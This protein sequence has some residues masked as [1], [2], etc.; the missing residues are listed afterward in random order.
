MKLKMLLVL[1]GNTDIRFVNGLCERFDVTILGPKSNLQV[2]GGLLDRIKERGLKVDVI[3]IE[4]GR[5]KYQVAAFFQLL[6]V[7]SLFDFIFSQENLRGTLN[8]G[9]VGRLKGVPVFSH[10]GMPPR[11]Y[12]RCRYQRK[13]ISWF[14][15]VVGDFVIHLLLRMNSLFCHYWFAL[16]PYLMEVFS[17]YKKGVIHA[18]YYGVNTELY[19]PKSGE[20]KLKLRSELEIDANKFLVFFS[21]RVSH[22]K[23]PETVLKAI[24][25]LYLAHSNLI[26]MNLSG[27]HEK[28]RE[29]AKMMN[30]KNID[31]WLITRAPAHPMID[32]P[33]YY[34]ASDLV[35]QSSLEEGLGLSPLEGMACEVP[36]IATDVGGMKAHLHPYCEMVPLQDVESMKGSI[37]K[38]MENPPSKEQLHKGRDYVI[39]CW[40][41]KMAFDELSQNIFSRVSLPSKGH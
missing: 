21:S 1:E 33:R 39:R 7:A 14:R 35:I 31:K 28:M 13:Q 27:G 24:A 18:H 38:M 25:D 36:V 22:E 19:I 40:S 32:L 30:L 16:G 10:S 26:L 23:D 8:A 3:E 17:A 9:I 12:Y 11:E 37:E 5:L 41:D 34:Q 4:G 2:T 29:L 6:K 20:D 15:Y